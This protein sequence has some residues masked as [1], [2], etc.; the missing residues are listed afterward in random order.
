MCFLVF[1][2]YLIRESQNGLMMIG[3]FFLSIW[4]TDVFAYYGGRTFGKTPLSSVS[5]KKTVEGTV[6]GVLAAGLIILGLCNAYDLSYFFV[7]AA[8]I[9]GLMGQLGDLYES[10]I[11]RTHNVKDSSNLL[12]AWWY[13]G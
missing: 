8:F 4:A 6:S 13:I 11:K 5:P 1:F 2:I 12:P 7:F 9:I 3:V 10:L